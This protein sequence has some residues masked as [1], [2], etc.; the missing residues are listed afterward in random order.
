M[1]VFELRRTIVIYLILY[2]DQIIC[3]KCTTVIKHVNCQIK[4]IEPYKQ[5]YEKW[6]VLWIKFGNSSTQFNRVVDETDVKI[7]KEKCEVRFQY[8]LEL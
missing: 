6:I 8:D 5:I 1:S 7:R 4:N 3:K 2:S